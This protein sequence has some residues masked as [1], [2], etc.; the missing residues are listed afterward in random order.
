MRWSAALAPYLGCGCGAG[1]SARSIPAAAA[2]WLVF[3][4]AVAALRLTAAM[5]AARL[6][7]RKAACS[8]GAPSWLDGMHALVPVALAGAA[9]ALFAP[10][11]FGAHPKPAIAFAGAAAAA[12]VMSPC[13][14][15]AVSMAA[16]LRSTLPAACAGFL[17][18]A[19]IADARAW[20][21]ANH[22]SARHDA[23]AYALAGT[24]CAIAAAHNGAGLVH[25][26]FAPGLYACA[27]ACAY[28]VCRYRRERCGALRVA[29]LI[30]LAGTVLAAPPPQYHATETTLA[31][32]FAGERVDFTGSIVRTNS[33][34]AL[35]RYAITCC[36]ADA[37]PVVLR[38]ASPVPS[39]ARGWAHARGSS[40]RQTATCVCAYS[41]CKAS[42]NPPI[43][44]CTARTS[45]R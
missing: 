33:A 10:T 45:F 31:D 29:P 21:R 41:R 20:M 26:H 2:A 30:M 11:I 23:L 25:P 32:A 39:A 15:G 24:A 36:R 44:F 6:A 28:A 1:P 35:V 38:L 27:A 43:R 18:V 34:V 16:A 5:L 3:G 4:P 17:C 42:A 9:C 12:F 8:H 22:A 19:G 7:S 40:K 37:A 14:L 13:A